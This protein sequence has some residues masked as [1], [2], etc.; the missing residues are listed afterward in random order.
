MEFVTQCLVG[1]ALT[2]MFIITPEQSLALRLSLIL[3]IWLAGVTSIDLQY[4]NWWGF[5]NNYTLGVAINRLLGYLGA[6]L[7]IS[8]ISGV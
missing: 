5:S 3:I 4:W 6:M 8:F 7:L 2:L 1:I